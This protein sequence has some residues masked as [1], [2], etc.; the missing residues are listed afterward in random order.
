MER[1]IVKQTDTTQAVEGEVRAFLRWTPSGMERVQGPIGGA[2]R[3]R[4]RAYARAARGGHAVV[5]QLRP[6]LPVAAS[7]E[8]RRALEVSTGV[9]AEATSIA[10]RTLARR[11]R[12]GRL[13]KDESER[14]LRIGA[15]R[16][17][18][19]EVLEDPQAA[20]QWLKSPKRALGGATPLEYADTEPGAR[21]VEDLLRRLE[22]GVF[23]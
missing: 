8:L 7:E 4:P 17:R 14:V 13:R 22:D 15:L 11:K 19:T 2:A 1:S 9:L 18:A 16:R 12:E 21:E 6:G 10:V 23:S 3:R 5:E 20:R